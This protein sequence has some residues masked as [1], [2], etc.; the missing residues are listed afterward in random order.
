[1]ARANGLSFFRTACG[2]VLSLFVARLGWLSATFWAPITTLVIAQPSFS[3]AWTPSLQ[4]SIGTRLGAVLGA[5]LVGR[6]GANPMAY[7]LSIFIL[8]LLSAATHVDR[9]GFRIGSLML[10]IIMLIQRT[11][12]VWR[13]ALE[14]FAEVSVGILVALFLVKVWP[15]AATDTEPHTP[16]PHVDEP[17]IQEL[18]P[19]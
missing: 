14:R 10:T 13:V 7:G 12:P 3:E 9:T 15:E 1:M 16:Q 4:R 19:L 17:M 5:L 18:P 6:L 2:A 11:D 8:L